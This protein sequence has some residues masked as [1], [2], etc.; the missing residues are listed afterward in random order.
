MRQYKSFVGFFCSALLALVSSRAKAAD[1]VLAAS[2][3]ISSIS[4]DSS[5]FDGTNFGVLPPLF[6]VDRLAGGTFMA[7]Y[8]F[9]TVT[10]AL[11]S[12]A[13]YPLSASS[14]LNYDLLDASGQLVHHG[15]DSSDP[16]AILQNNSGT[17]P[18]TVD[19]VLLGAFVNSI[20]GL[21]VPTPLYGPTGDVFS[22]GDIIVF[23]NVD[24]SVDYLTDLAIPTDAA[25]YLAF[26]E[27]ASRMVLEFGDGDYSK[28]VDPFQ[29]AV[30]YLEYDI[31]ALTVTPVPEPATVILLMSAMLIIGF[32]RHCGK[33][34]H[35]HRLPVVLLS[36][37]W[38]AHQRDPMLPR[39]W[40]R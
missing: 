27:M 17:A 7:T 18:F 40:I 29:Y 22:S 34:R 8:R 15:G 20:T 11:G 23:G 14:M 26:P 9:S 5:T 24:G 12:F 2:G 30:T 1:Y 19:Q 32:H 25:T 16:I 36:S 21:L 35:V 6:D 4:S 39:S 31:A 38:N 10:P 37:S 3:P 33:T 28:M 13:F